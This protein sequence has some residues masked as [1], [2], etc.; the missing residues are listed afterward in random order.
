MQIILLYVPIW[1]VYLHF[2][3]NIPNIFSEQTMKTH[4]TFFI[5]AVK[6]VLSL[7]EFSEAHYTH[8]LLQ[9]KNLN[10]F[11]YILPIRAIVRRSFSI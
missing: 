11:A 1:Y 9:F 8:F 2:E 4:Q 5:I 10:L 6:H 3:A 7:R